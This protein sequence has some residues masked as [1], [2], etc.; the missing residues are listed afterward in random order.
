MK[1][2]YV[3]TVG[4][5]MGFFKTFI[6]TLLDEG[7]TVD[8][9]TNDAAAPVQD[10]YREW[11]CNIHQISCTRSPVNKGSMRAI[12]EI[13][14]LVTEN[15]YDIVHCHTPVAAMCTR[16]ACR[17]LRKK[18]GVR[19][20]YTAHGFHF[21]K[22]APKKNWLMYYPIEKIC[23]RWTDTLITINK[24]DY[25]FAQKKMKAKEVVYVPGVGID[26]DK[27]ANTIIDR[28]SKR[29]ELGVSTDAFLMLS[30]GEL[31]ENK[32][33]KTVIKAMAQLENKNVYYAIAGK[34]E[35]D[36]ELLALANELGLGERFKL[37]GFRSDVAELYKVADCFV[38]PS[39]RE[40]LPVS[41]MEAMASGL[42][43]LASNIRGCADLVDHNGGSLF[44]ACSVEECANSLK[45][46]IE[47]NTEK[48]KKFNQNRSTEF[49]KAIIN[50]EMKKIYFKSGVTEM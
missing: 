22:G 43:I 8:I 25:A 44:N 49:D 37:L 42:P 2:L 39:F 24:E 32:N 34:G 4:S 38:H 40:G 36:S 27:F 33:H 41:I 29:Q 14:K 20:I 11:G 35:L 45:I 7:H 3:T 26:V 5:T 12:K 46:V 17:K 21:Y 1:I 23:S 47:N 28:E 6:R 9:A 50:A 30:V 19:V 31:N 48:M 18:K 13:K 15:E 16:L 10:Y